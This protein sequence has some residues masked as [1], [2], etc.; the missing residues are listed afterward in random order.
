[1]NK[2]YNEK[3]IEFASQLDK[4]DIIDIFYYGILVKENCLIL[5]TVQDNYFCK[6]LIVYLNGFSR[7]TIDLENQDGLWIKKIKY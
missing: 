5:E 7:E 6:G 2:K 4:S 1:M 3:D